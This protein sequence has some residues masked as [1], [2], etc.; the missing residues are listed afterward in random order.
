M[1]GNGNSDA[2]MFTDIWTLF[3][4]II[5]IDIIFGIISIVIS[6]VLHNVNN[7]ID[8]V[9]QNT[10]NLKYF[11]STENGFYIVRNNHDASETMYFK[12]Y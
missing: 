1:V 7:K 11:K 10:D 6:I 5:A 8:K 12:R 9:N 3:L 2:D 4:L